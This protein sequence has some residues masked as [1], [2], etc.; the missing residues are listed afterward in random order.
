MPGPCQTLYTCS[1]S[2]ELANTQIFLCTTVH[3]DR[4]TQT[5]CRW[6]EKN[7]HACTCTVNISWLWPRVVKK[8]GICP[9]QVRTTLRGRAHRV[10]WRK[11]ASD[12]HGRIRKVLLQSQCFGKSHAPRR[13]GRCEKSWSDSERALQRWDQSDCHTLWLSAFLSWDS[14]WLFNL[15]VK[16]Q[17]GKILKDLFN[18]TSH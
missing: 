10:G 17:G 9:S 15:A 18:P 3:A 11:T 5:H 12:L 7:T 2:I 8:K 16:R 1:H 14:W 6:T 13:P 4:H